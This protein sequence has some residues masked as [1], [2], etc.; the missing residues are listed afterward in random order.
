MSKSVV[1]EKTTTRSAFL[2]QVGEA[3]RSPAEGVALTIQSEL[4]PEDCAALLAEHCGGTREFWQRTIAGGLCV[5]RNMLQCLRS[6]L[7]RRGLAALAEGSQMLLSST[8]GKKYVPTEKEP[9]LPFIPGRNP[10]FFV[11]VGSRRRKKVLE[12]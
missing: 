11:R 12:G 2:M 4:T 7:V 9:E 5:G 10:R 1:P 3:L 6:L 8:C